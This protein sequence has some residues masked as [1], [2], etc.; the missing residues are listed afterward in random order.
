MNGE[1]GEINFRVHWLSFT[2]HGSTR[3]AFALYDNFFRDIFGDLEDLGHGGRFFKTI[4]KGLL[5]VKLYLD[6][7]NQ[8][9]ECFQIELPGNAC[10]HIPWDYFHALDIYLQAN[11]EGQYKYKR[12]DLAFDNVP[13]TP[14]EVQSAIENEN[15]RSLAKKKTLKF[16]GSP[17]EER[18]NGEIGTYTIEFGSDKSERKITVYNKR[19]YIRLEFQVT[20]DRAQIVASDL[21]GE[22]NITKWYEIMIGHL[23]DYI[24]FDMP[25]WSEFIESNSRAWAI[26]STPK[27]VSK[28]KLTEWIE[29]QV[30]PAL[31]VLIDTEPPEIIEAMIRR[32]RNRRG[33]RY[34]LLLGE[35]HDG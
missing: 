14:Q 27:E 23:R 15:Y 32:G 12:L 18:E 21:F 26:I 11:F 28:E 10:D 8:D 24:D 30:T 1:N 25:W 16:H 2:V 4:L 20:N 13:F 22:S 34:N 5:E 31:S 6:F 33:P 17:F 3:D 19:G 29:T 7:S 9:I 35:V